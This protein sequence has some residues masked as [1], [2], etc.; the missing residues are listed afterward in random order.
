MNELHN[1]YDLSLE[2]KSSKT[3]KVHEQRLPPPQNKAIKNKDN[4]VS[5]DPPSFLKKGHLNI[6]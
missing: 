5:F 3:S 6:F 2:E 4:L 1:T